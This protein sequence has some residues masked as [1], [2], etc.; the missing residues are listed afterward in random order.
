M[1]M[2]FKGVEGSGIK[3]RDKSHDDSSCSDLERIRESME[4][5]KIQ[6]LTTYNQLKQE[7]APSCEMRKI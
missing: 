1:K 5:L 6:T 4:R 7:Q 3:R 2:F